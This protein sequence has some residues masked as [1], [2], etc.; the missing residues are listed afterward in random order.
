MAL[1]ASQPGPPALSA[2]SAFSSSPALQALASFYEPPSPLSPEPAGSVIRSMVIPS[3]TALPAG[4]TA[5]RILYH[6]ESVDGAD[7][8]V[9]GVVVVPDGTPPPG[10]F[11]IVSWAHGT[12]GLAAACAPS[13][14]G[15]ASIPYLDTLIGART[16]VAATDYQGPG[17]AGLTPYLVGVGEAQNVLDAARAARDLEG[18]AASNTVVVLGHSQGGQAALF[19]G[20]IAQSYAPELFVAGIAAA[21]PVT[22]LLEFAPPSGRHPPGDSTYYAVMALYAWST[23]YGNFP[24]TSVLTE[25]AIRRSTV[26]TT[27]CMADVESVYGTIPAGALL[28][29]GWSRNAAVGLD[30]EANDPGLSPTSA[31]VL[32]VQGTG[33]A[34]IPYPATTAFVRTQLC[35]AEH[36]TVRYLPVSGA[37][38]SG[39][40]IAAASDVLGWIAQRLRGAPAT[41]T[42]GRLGRPASG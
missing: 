10:G 27:G 21:A 14:L 16:I 41:S 1:G 38:H 9:S 29:P 37:G 30:I 28:A 40:L 5:Y 36:D 13:T 35:A 19:A 33:D 42:C 22:S 32:V 7:N 8:A 24:L 23:T 20:Q 18:T 39:V 31:P 12:T 4:A 11:P 2:H 34:L 3:G 15:T 26:I 17:T 25:E 6:S